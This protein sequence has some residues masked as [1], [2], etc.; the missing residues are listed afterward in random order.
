MSKTSDQIEKQDPTQVNSEPDAADAERPTLRR[1]RRMRFVH[2]H[3][4]AIRWSL[5]ALLVIAAVY[6]LAITK[7]LMVPLV[8]AMFLGF[9]LNPLVASA[10]RIGVPR[11][12]AAFVIML[13]VAGSI[14][15]GIALLAPEAVDWVQRAPE[16]VHEIKPKIESFTHQLQEATEATQALV[17][18][19]TPVA[20]AAV[21]AVPAAISTWDVLALTP[22]VLAFALTVA[23]LVFF[24]LVYGDALLLRLVEISP[25]FA[26]KRHAVDLVRSIQ[27]ELSHFIFAAT[28]INL[29]LGALTAALL[30]WLEMPDPLL[31]GGV[32]ALANF[33]PYLGAIVITCVFA[34]VGLLN[35]DTLTQALLPALGFAALNAVE[36]NVVTPLIL[37]RRLRLSPVAILLWLLIWFWLWG[38]AGALLAV[39]M[40]TSAKLISEHVRGWEWF[41]KMVGR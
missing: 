36:G 15:G 16:L 3:L 40:L 31:W 33:V 41:A 23:L 35:F 38:I 21:A 30:W 32:A 29:T 28:C 6:T 1:S 10:A 14:S 22:N 17:D 18:T 20:A 5:S 24:F 8:L 37:G 39:P 2:T 12:V 19:G 27:S 4:V 34:L 26:T 7:T 25:S 9:G 11:S 13:V